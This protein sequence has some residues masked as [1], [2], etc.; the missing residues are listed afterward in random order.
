MPS[1]KDVKLGDP[2]GIKVNDS[3]L[4]NGMTIQSLI[5]L[6]QTYHGGKVIVGHDTLYC[7]QPHYHI[8]WFSVKETSE[9]AMKTFR[10]NVIKKKFPHISKSFR[11]YTGQDLPSAEKDIWLA[12]AIKET[13]VSSDYS[14]TEEIKVLAKSRFQ[15]KQMKSVA[16]EKKAND[17]KE[18]K[19]FREKMILSIKEDFEMYVPSGPH[20]FNDFDKIK[21][22]IIRYLKQHRPTSLRRGIIDAYVIPCCIEIFGWDETQIYKYLYQV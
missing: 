15:I 5:E 8:H 4:I 9:G 10:S 11:F 6:C 2:M 16:S 12:Y 18:K 3:E 14:I 20:Q 19:D 7:Q 1:I 17:D 13:L 22:L 21:L